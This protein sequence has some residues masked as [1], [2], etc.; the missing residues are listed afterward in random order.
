M[1][2]AA[3]IFSVDHCV[4][5]VILK[6]LFFLLIAHKLG[7]LFQMVFVCQHGEGLRAVA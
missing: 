2:E 6:A 5:L 1:S 4:E 3:I 7:V